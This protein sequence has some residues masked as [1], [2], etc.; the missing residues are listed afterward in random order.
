M[1]LPQAL[2]EGGTPGGSAGAAR[3]RRRG[4]ERLPGEPPP[5]EGRGSLPAWGR[6]GGEKGD[7]EERRRTQEERESRLR[8]RE[9]EGE[10]EGGRAGEPRET[11]VK[12]GDF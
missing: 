5:G 11:P 1:S 12:G 4:G 10:G 7:S 8:E 6:R 2:P 3:R 9:E